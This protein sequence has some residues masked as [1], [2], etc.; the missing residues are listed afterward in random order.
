MVSAVG[1]SVERTDSYRWSGLSRGRRPFVVVQATIDGAGRYT[2][3][4]GEHRI[5][6][7]QAMLAVIPGDHEYTVDPDIGRW[8]FA[9]AVVYGEE[10]MR[11]AT[12]IRAS[13]GAVL[14]WPESSRAD[15]TLYELAHR[16]MEGPRASAFELSALVY[17]L[18]MSLAEPP[19]PQPAPGRVEQAALAIRRNLHAPVSVDDLAA[20]T[21]LSRFHFS[22]LFTEQTGLS[23]VRYLQEVRIER[24]IGLLV[25]STLAVKEIA[26]ACGYRSESYFC[27]AFKNA[28]GLTPLEYRRSRGAYPSSG[29]A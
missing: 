13:R 18:L 27:R 19:L 16:L 3:P 25:S 5:E 26:G 10:V 21:G 1:H 7:G 17:A 22:R 15:G 4:S 2:D 29:R 9:Y 14:A 23:P 12:A 6:P 8:E 11:I 20:S 28:T 24:A